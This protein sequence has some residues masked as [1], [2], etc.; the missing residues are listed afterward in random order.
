MMATGTVLLFEG[1]DGLW[2][3]DDRP[4]D[5]VATIILTNVKSYIDSFRKPLELGCGWFVSEKMDIEQAKQLTF[6]EG[7]AG[8]PKV[9]TRELSIEGG[10]KDRMGRWLGIPGYFPY[11]NLP[12]STDIES[13]SEEHS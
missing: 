11:I 6:K 12:E 1:P 9:V 7:I 8:D 4:V 10:I 2:T 13:S 5:N 3:Q